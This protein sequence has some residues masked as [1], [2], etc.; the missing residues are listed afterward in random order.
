MMN[1]TAAILALALT[2]G[3]LAACGTDEADS[4]GTD[5]PTPAVSTATDANEPSQ[6]SADAPPTALLQENF[7]GSYGPGSE[8]SWYGFISGFLIDFE[9]IEVETTLHDDGDAAKPAEAICNAALGAS[10]D[11]E[12]PIASAKVLDQNGDTLTECEPNL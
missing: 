4:G 10:T 8:T 6:P 9:T 2:I 5:D 7:G 3:A 11:L 1:K 12:D